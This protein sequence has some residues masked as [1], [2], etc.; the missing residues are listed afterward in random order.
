[1]ICASKQLSK[2]EN[3][4][5]E[6]RGIEATATKYT[7]LAV[8]SSFTTLL[9]IIWMCLMMVLPKTNTIINIANVLNLF[10]TFSDVV[11]VTLTFSF[12]NTGYKKLCGICN[13]GLLRL[14]GNDRVDKV[15]TKQLKLE[16]GGR[17]SKIEDS[18]TQTDGIDVSSKADE[19]TSPTLADNRTITGSRASGMTFVIS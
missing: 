11:T 3:V 6:E 10:D 12:A 4:S 13:D 18:Q 8:F 16:V 5:M 7:V 9:M 15:M 1:M 2:I 17:S 14:C 19:T